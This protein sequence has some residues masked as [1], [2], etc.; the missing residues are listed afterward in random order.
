[1]REKKKATPK[2]VMPTQIIGALHIN[3]D[4]NG[5][6]HLNTEKI[7]YW[8]MGMYTKNATTGKKTATLPALGTIASVFTQFGRQDVMVVQ[9]FESGVDAASQTQVSHLRRVFTTSDEGSTD[10][11]VQHEYEA[12]MLKN[13]LK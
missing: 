1:M 4:D 10:Q 3:V 5:Q 6:Q 12:Y 8:R 11:I 13:H 2:Q 9:T 7:F